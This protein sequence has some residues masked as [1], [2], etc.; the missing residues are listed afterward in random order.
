VRCVIA[1]VALAGPAEA[2]RAPVLRQ[3]RTPHPYY[4]REMLI[5]QVTTGPSAATWSPDGRELIYS[6]QGSLWRQRIGETEARQLTDGPGYHHQ[7]D[8]SPDGRRVVYAS[9]RDDVIGLWLLDLESGHSSPLVSDSAVSI[10]PLR[11]TRACG[12]SSS[13]QWVPRPL[14]GPRC[15]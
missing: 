11:P 6:M 12:M 15:G 4:F 13:C 1:V 3:V 8:W 14:P 9:Y 10:E 7:P 5:P 2:Q